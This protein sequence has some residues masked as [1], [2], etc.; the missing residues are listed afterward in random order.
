MPDNGPPPP[1][2]RRGTAD[3]VAIIL[4]AG[5]AV[6]LNIITFAL[7]YAAMIRLG[8]G[9][10][11]GLSENGTQ[12]LSAWGGGILSILAAYVGYAFGVHRAGKNG[13]PPA[14]PPPPP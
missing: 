6:A 13:G 14:D 9:S 11:M 2:R 4:A 5:M 3:H 8:V 10:N 12:I 1:H 7:L